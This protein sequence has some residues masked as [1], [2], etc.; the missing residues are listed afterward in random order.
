M[1]MQENVRA[2]D[3]MRGDFKQCDSIVKHSNLT[4]VSG[5]D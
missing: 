2:H 5:V 4:K 1:T 3:G